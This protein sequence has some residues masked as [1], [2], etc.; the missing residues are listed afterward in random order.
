MDA[1]GDVLHSF[2]LRHCAEHFQEQSH[3]RQRRHNSL[4]TDLEAEISV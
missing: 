4:G 2:F 3:L 1:L